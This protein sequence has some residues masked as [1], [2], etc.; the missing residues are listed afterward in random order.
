[1]PSFHSLTITDVRRETPDA[2]SL[3]FAVPEDLADAYRFRAGQYLTLRAEIGGEE[4]RRSYSICSGLD[5]GE[6]RVAV[7]KV[8]DGRFSTY[9]ND[10]LAPG[11]SLEV[12]TPDGQFAADVDPD[13]AR[14]Y[15]LFAAGSGITPILGIA[16]TVLAREPK[17]RVTLFYGNRTTADILFRE[18]LEDLKNRYT[19]RFSLLHVLSR[20]VQDTTLLNGRIDR[21]K[22]AVFF[23]TLVNVHAV[24]H[25]F[26]CGPHPMVEEI[27]ASL[28]DHGAEPGRV[29]VELFTAGDGTPREP[30]SVSAGGSADAA[31]PVEGMARVSIVLD[32]M[33]TT[34]DLA[35]DGEPILDAALGHRADVPYAC[36]GGMCCTCRAKLVDGDVSMDVN[37][38][39]APE[40]IARGFVLA[41]QAHPRS[42]TVTLDFDQR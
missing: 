9:A 36:K 38:T 34:F 13:T 24:D 37:Y 17:S 11:M 20:E 8:A 10:D 16:K 15:V 40:E 18:T 28:A 2:V 19:D 14:T 6:L 27:R 7:K 3:A 29:H 39:L 12:M 41:C 42:G 22:C 33:T 23:K 4:V 5:D 21:E 26:L 30:V 35:P 32:G 25:F 31:A 1:M